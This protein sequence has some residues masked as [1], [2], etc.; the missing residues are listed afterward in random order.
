MSAALTGA[1]RVY[2]GHL[3]EGTITQRH[4]YFPSVAWCLGN[5]G[6]LLRLLCLEVEV[7]VVREC[8][9]IQELAVEVDSHFTVRAACHI[10]SALGEQGHSVVVKALHLE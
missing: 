10:V 1:N 3:L 6:E 9:D 4:Y 5:L 7:N 8:V 2:K